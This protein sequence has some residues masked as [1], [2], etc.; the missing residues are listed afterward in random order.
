M[1]TV[2]KMIIWLAPLFLLCAC[3]GGAATASGTS[4]PVSVAPASPSTPPVWTLDW[5]DEFDGTSLD[6]GKWVEETGG[7]GWGNNE[8][9]YYTSRSENVRVANGNLII[10]ARKEA[11]GGRDYTSARIKTAGLQERAYGRYEARMKIPKGQ[12]M[13][14]A[15]WMLGNDIGTAGWP[16]CGE[17]DIMENIGKAPATVYGTV[18]GP[19]YSGANGFGGSTSLASG[20][21]ADDYHLYAME[22]EPTE[23]RWYLDGKLYH[24][25]TPTLVA[26]K[27]VFDHPFF[28]ILN[29]AVGGNWPG[30]PDAGT[31]FPQQLLVDYVR[32]Y[33]RAN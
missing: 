3:G 18:H 29:L 2:K 28:I 6:H 1:M 8:L 11:F 9:E 27:W 33:R 10:E 17:I 7:D 14:P 20:A 15:F 22:W 13:W 16:A 30:S 12:G 4:A 19:G 24:T 21:L 31:V 26:G 23:I 32:V 5:S 25:A